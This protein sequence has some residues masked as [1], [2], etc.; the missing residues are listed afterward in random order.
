MIVKIKIKGYL[1]LLFVCALFFLNQLY[2]QK[3]VLNKKNYQSALKKCIDSVKQASRELSV[4]I[5]RC[6]SDVSDSLS[7]F[8]SQI[9]AKF[10][11]CSHVFKGCKFF[12]EDA[13]PLAARPIN[14]ALFKGERTLK[15]QNCSFL[16]PGI[17]IQKLVNNVSQKP[18]LKQSMVPTVIEEK[19][20]VVA[21]PE[22][23]S[24]PVIS[25]NMIDLSK[26]IDDIYAFIDT[27]MSS[28]V[29]VITDKIA[30]LFSALDSKINNLEVASDL[31][32]RI[33]QLDDGMKKMFDAVNDRISSLK[34]ARDLKKVFVQVEKMDEELRNVVAMVDKRLDTVATNKTK[35]GT[36]IWDEVQ[37]LNSYIEKIYMMLNKKIKMVKLQSQQNASQDKKNVSWNEINEL[38][39]KIEILSNTLN[40]KMKVLRLEVESKT[41]DGATTLAQSIDKISQNFDKNLKNLKSEVDL[42]ALQTSQVANVEK[43]IVDQVQNINTR[44]A[45]LSIELSGLSKSPKT[46]KMIDSLKARIDGLNTQVGQIK[47]EILTQTDQQSNSL[48]NEIDT[49]NNTVDELKKSKVLTVHKALSDSSDS[50]IKEEVKKQLS[51]LRENSMKAK[52]ARKKERLKKLLDYV[53]E[54][55]DE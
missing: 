38:N 27:K 39:S 40:Q 55:E 7:F 2:S 8:G 1:K 16:C 49:I 18:I 5:G 42:L 17:Q 41:K 32:D 14:S 54:K 26:R 53:L 20:V 48:W 24:V 13:H 21:Y 22:S 23:Q 43:T 11:A 28:T 12:S 29:D 36:E 3:D 51:S 6:V 31:G 52:H 4:N 25:D 10:S 45:E 30:V 19:K 34:E 33:V 15:G 35:A 46:Q 50:K 37:S 9:G 44:V 47:Q